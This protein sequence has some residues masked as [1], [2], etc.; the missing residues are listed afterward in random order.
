[1]IRVFALSLL[2]AAPALAQQAHDGTVRT[3][4]MPELSDLALAAFAVGAVWF[5]RRALRVRF[6]KD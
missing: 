4:S 6:R 3:R 1:M 5:V 2:L